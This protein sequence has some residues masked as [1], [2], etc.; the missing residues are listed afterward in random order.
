MISTY[1]HQNYNDPDTDELMEI[2]YVYCDK[3][4]GAY[5][6]T[7][8]VMNYDLGEPDFELKTRRI[9]GPDGTKYLVNL[10]TTG[11][12]GKN[13]LKWPQSAEEWLQLQVKDAWCKE[14]MERITNDISLKTITIAQL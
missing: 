11:R 6:S 12:L 3:E 8:R 9:N 1:V 13:D 2:I 14:M 5:M 10:A 7:A 4:T